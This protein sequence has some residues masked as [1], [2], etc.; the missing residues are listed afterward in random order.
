MKFSNSKAQAAIAIIPGKKIKKLG[1]R[2]IKR[3]SSSGNLI[4]PIIAVTKTIVSH[5][6][7]K[8]IT[9]DINLPTT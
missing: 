3:D 5:N 1:N 9:F 4:M 2:D 6:D 8:I 7:N